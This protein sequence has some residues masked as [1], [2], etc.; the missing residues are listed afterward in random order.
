MNSSSTMN[1]AVIGGGAAGFFAAL[2][3][4]EHHPKATVV[5]LEKTHQ[6][7][8]KVKISGGGR[9]NVT[10]DCKYPAQLVKNYPRG[11]HWLKKPFTQFSSPDTIKWFEQRGVALKVESDG[12]IFPVSDSSASIINCLVDECK[13][14]GIE[15]RTKAG[16]EKIIPSEKTIRLVFKDGSDQVFEK[17]II[18]SGGNAKKEAY[19]W[20]SD[21]GHTIITPVPSLFTFNIPNSPITKLMGV[22]A[23]HV[24]VAIRDT[25]LIET[26]PLLIT[27]WGMSGP[28]TLKLSS[29]A[30]RILHEKDYH[31]YI[32]VTWESEMT[33]RQ[34]HEAMNK[35]GNKLLK[36]YNPTSL[37]T[38]LWEYLIEQS[39]LDPNKP[40]QEQAKKGKNRLINLLKDD[41]YQVSGKTTFKEE[42]VTCGGVSLDEIDQ[43]TMESKIIPHLYFAG[44][45]MDID[46]VTGGFNF[47]SSW[48]TGYLAGK[49]ASN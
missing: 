6:Y 9:C 3:V 29:W 13:Q 33:E 37:P 46:A 24:K 45:V 43:I 39:G 15:I 27:H 42:F 11:K 28:A 32:Q 31:F 18:A 12:R 21:L 7:L 22:V 41:H 1:V 14:L 48:T 40:W 5:I 35:S 36:N 44:E 23:P 17:V 4:K 38:R 49:L 8:T 20:L 10:H 16:V 26:G 2:S 19:R 47:Q 25:K 30:A 34:L